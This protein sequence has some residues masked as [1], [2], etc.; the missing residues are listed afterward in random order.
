MSKATSFPAQ[1]MQVSYFSIY[2]T[3][4][5]LIL[6]NLTHFKSRACQREAR[7]LK[8]SKKYQFHD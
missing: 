3:G 1:I 6:L 2:W 5:E 8:G 7:F 4:F